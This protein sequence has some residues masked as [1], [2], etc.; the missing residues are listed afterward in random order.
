M[1]EEL[2]Q[3]FITESE[4]SI[5]QLNNS[6]LELESNPE[7]TDAIDDIF[8]Q[9]HTLKGNFGAMGF[10]NAA[11]VA[12][13]VEDLLDEIRH[14]RLAVTPDRMDLVFD[15]MDEILEILRD[16]EEH[17]ESKSDPT[18]L[19]EEIRAAARA[20]DAAGEEPSTADDDDAPNDDALAVAAET[21]DFESDELTDAELLY[22]ADIELNAGEMK[23]VDAGLFLGGVPD[24]VDVV[25]SVPDIDSI[26]DGEFDDGFA[27]FVANVPEAELGPTLAGLWKVESVELTDVSA[28]LADDRDAEAALADSDA[29]ADAGAAVDADAAEVDAEPVES[30]AAD[31]AEAEAAALAETSEADA[32]PD[33]EPEEAEDGDPAAAV[34]PAEAAEAVAAVEAAY[35]GAESESEQESESEDGRE[36][37]RDAGGESVS[38]ADGDA[39]AA[40]A[41]AAESGAEG[42]AEGADSP[43]RD[44]ADE[45]TKAEGEKKREKRE[46][47]QSISAVK[48]VRVD[49]DQLDEL[50]ELVEQ[51]VTSR[52]KLRQA[53][54]G[55]VVDTTSGLDTLDELDKISTNLQNTVMDMRL[56]PLKKVFDKFPRL[57]RDLARDQDK[58]V[59]FTVE[60]EDIELDRTILDEISDPLMH[61]LRN[62]V[63]HGIELPDEREA[64]GKPRT[65]TVELSA[66]REHDTVVITASD[67]GSGINADAVR[68]KAVSNGLAT[69][70]E[71]NAMPD[72][73]VYDYI[74]HPGFSTNEEITDV[75]G[76][77]VGMDVVKTTVEALDGS[78]SVTSTPGEGSVF[79]I[80]LPVSV[81]IIKVLFVRVGDREFGVP[82]KYID[83]IS[84]RQ[85][86]QTINGAEVVVHEDS[87]FPLIRLRDA[88]DIDVA[89]GDGGMIVRIR[90]SDRQVALHCDHVTRQEEVVVTPLQGPLGGTQ[91]LSGTAVIGDGNVIPIL[92]VSTLELPSGGREALREWTPPSDGE[93]AEGSADTDADGPAEVEEAA[94]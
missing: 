69:R 75:S 63:D 4:E 32:E 24:G 10:D 85:K 74:F 68:E 56:I 70:E 42:S 1:D 13:A 36:S 83:E 73:E 26:E 94:D 90:P 33:A 87:L 88:L 62:A 30:G 78:A 93:S 92:D 37:D 8:R 31:D 66:H 11:T 28:V 51:L 44:D 9:A 58:R 71:L 15:G 67:D 43:A 54:E 18:A 25:G 79:T 14:D 86:V 47:G 19:V 20:E 40:E 34:D 57:V 17:G 5:T 52:I 48:S 23:G 84:R 39:G 72:E 91:G 45:E 16:I 77:G 38:D 12:H 89:E 65:G 55:E 80:R 22:H 50:H 49:V 35:S 64:N 59:R 53:M 81:A 82:I 7:A 6:L 61:V 21:L 60:G 29:E 27:L 41:T 3:A 46:K 76:R 2:Y